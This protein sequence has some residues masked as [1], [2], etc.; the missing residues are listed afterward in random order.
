VLD[1][2]SGSDDGGNDTVERTVGAR[3]L[4]LC[5]RFPIYPQR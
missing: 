5:T 2:L 1:G 4:E 3:V